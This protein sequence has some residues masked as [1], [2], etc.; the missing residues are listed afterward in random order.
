MVVSFDNPAQNP[1]LSGSQQRK[2]RRG[3]LRYELTT[4]S[5]LLGFRSNRL[6]LTF[7]H[8]PSHADIA[9]SELRLALV[10][11]KHDIVIYHP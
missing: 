3:D 8:T 1:T 2:D 4:E 5:G 9:R 11:Q 7:P 10:Q 6:P